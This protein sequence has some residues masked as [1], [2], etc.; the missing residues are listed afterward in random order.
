MTLRPRLSHCTLANEVLI[1]RSDT[2]HQQHVQGQR[3]QSNRR[4]E[5]GIDQHHHQIQQCKNDVERTHKRCTREKAAN[6]VQFP[7]PLGEFTHRPFLEIS[8][9]QGQQ[10]ID[11]RCSQG[12]I[13]PIGGIHKDVGAQCHQHPLEQGQHHHHRTQHIEATEVSLA[14]NL[15]NDLLNQQR[16][17]QTK[18]LGQQ[19]CHKHQDQ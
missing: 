7:Q 8:Q 16:N 6:R 3:T 5:R 14:Q 19:R 18:Q 9:R 10:A 2:K 1:N 15:V 4:Q 12:E 13:H 11:H 17:R